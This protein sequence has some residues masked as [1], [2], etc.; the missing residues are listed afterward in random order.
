M[1][2]TKQ[3]V[4]CA[5]IYAAASLLSYALWVSASGFLAVTAT[6]PTPDRVL[7]LLQLSGNQGS[8]RLDGLSFF[9]LIPA[10]VGLFA[11]LRERKP[12]LAMT[13]AAFLAFSIV[14]LFQA[15][16]M[17][18]SMVTLVQGAV[19]DSLKERL[20]AINTIAFTYMMPG[21]WAGAVANLLFG[22]ALQAQT[23]TARTLGRLFLAQVAGFLIAFGGFGAQQDAVG[24]T[25]ILVQVLGGYGHLRSA[26][27]VAQADRE[28]GCRTGKASRTS[29][30]C[31]SLGVSFTSW[32]QDQD[33]AAW[34]RILMPR[35]ISLRNVFASWN[36]LG[37]GMTNL[38]RRYFV[39]VATA[40]SLSLAGRMA[41]LALPKPAPIIDTHLHCFAGTKDPRFAY[42]PKAPYRPEPAAT[43]EH[44][45]KCMEGAGVSHA[46]VVHPEPYQDDHRYLEYCLEVGKGRL[47]GTCLVFAD[48]PASV[49]QLPKLAK[50][51]DIV[52]VRVHAYAPD[53]LPPFG[54]PE[55]R[56]PME[57]SHRLGAGRATSF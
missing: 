35:G 28:R 8:A 56:T 2:S 27:N 14:A 16:T 51:G 55:L 25:G 26:G 7:S 17:N 49:A 1:G 5:L 13:G 39:Q 42:H 23:G 36:K 44:L 33:R 30:S 15:T 50:R 29:S 4:V 38:T 6:P 20:A 24:N 53:R 32:V 19:T 37:E 45:L 34:R 41:S 21:L 57:A 12:A 10:G 40:A 11:Y 47:K 31:R 52:A 54:K 18:L 43:P 46:I 48:Q 9:F 3:R 22:I